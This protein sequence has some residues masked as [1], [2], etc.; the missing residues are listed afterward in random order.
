MKEIFKCS[1]WS[2]RWGNT[3]ILSQTQMFKNDWS[4][5][6]LL[7][8]QI[9]EWEVTLLVHKELQLEMIFVISKSVQLFHVE[10]FSSLSPERE[11]SFL[12]SDISVSCSWIPC[13]SEVS[14]DGTL[15]SGIYRENTWD[16]Y[17]ISTSAAW[18]QKIR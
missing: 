10:Q 3:Q 16:K 15:L 4:A 13:C 2:L 14:S 8:Q 9:S 17:E 11:A 7:I 1:R 18:L 6:W 5:S 12:I